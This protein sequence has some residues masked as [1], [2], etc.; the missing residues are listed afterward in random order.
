VFLQKE[1]NL[2]KAM[3]LQAMLKRLWKKI[4]VLGR[5][6]RGIAAVE[7]AVLATLLVMVLGGV[8]DFGHGWYLKQLVVNA[9]REG[10]RYAVAFSVDS[11]AVRVKPQDVS[12]SVIT[13]TEGL[14]TGLSPNVTVTGTGY[15][16]GTKGDPVTV[17]VKVPKNWFIVKGFLPAGTLPTTLQATTTMLCE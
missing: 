5:E 9:S 8:I 7:F 10:A 4:R 2:Q 11:T 12:P 17:T 15:T 14:L 1:E 6:T 3:P 16:S 13:Y